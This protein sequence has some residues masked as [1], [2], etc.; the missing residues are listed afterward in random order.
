VALDGGVGGTLW[1]SQRVG[2][3]MKGVDRRPQAV[4]MACAFDEVLRLS[5]IAWARIAGEGVQRL[6]GDRI[7]TFARILRIDVYKVAH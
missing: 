3:V 6:G 7:D 4:L 5:H 1:G 2:P